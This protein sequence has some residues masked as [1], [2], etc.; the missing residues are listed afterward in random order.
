VHPSAL[1]V[2]Y[3]TDE[4]SHWNAAQSLSAYLKKYNVPGITGIDTRM[5]TKKL[6]VN[7]SMKGKLVIEVR[8]FCFRR[9]ALPQVA[10]ARFAAQCHRCVGCHCN[11]H[12]DIYSSAGG[13][14]GFCTQDSSLSTSYAIVSFRCRLPRRHHQHHSRHPHHVRHLHFH[15][16]CCHH[17]H[18]HFNLQGDDADKIEQYD[19]NVENLVEKVS[20][21]EV[22]VFNPEGR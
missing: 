17:H 12:A 5:L 7:G 10:L 2:S 6:R 11:E 3:L 9:S 14:G 1:I 15:H 4:Y 19:P 21:K 13:A 20:V 16:R 8:L 22:R 18:W